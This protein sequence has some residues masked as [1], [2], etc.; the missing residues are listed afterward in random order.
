MAPDSMLMAGSQQRYDQQN[1]KFQMEMFFSMCENILESIWT[2]SIQIR[3]RHSWLREDETHFRE[4]TS[5]DIM[6]LTFWVL[7]DN[8][9]FL[10]SCWAITV[11]FAADLC[12]PEDNENSNEND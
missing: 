6:V 1:T 8:A 4:L 12:S 7:Q 10:L 5:C 9:F 2:A 11:K 3:Y